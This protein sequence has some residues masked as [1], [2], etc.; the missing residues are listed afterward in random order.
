VKT[1]GS[2]RREPN[3]AVISGTT[4]VKKGEINEAGIT[5]K[6]RTKPLNIKQTYDFL[7]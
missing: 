4:N 2:E 3:T 1:K 5:I 6:S 7:F